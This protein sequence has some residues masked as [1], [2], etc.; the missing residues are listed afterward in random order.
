MHYLELGY[1]ERT[2]DIVRMSLTLPTITCTWILGTE[3]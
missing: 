2:A 1:R 3:T